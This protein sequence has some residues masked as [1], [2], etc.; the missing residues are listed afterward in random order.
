MRNSHSASKLDLFDRCPLAFRKRYIEKIKIPS[1]N[2]ALTFGSL[3]H[4][5]LESCYRYIVEEEIKGELSDSIVEECCKKAAL[6]I[7]IS[8]V[9]M[10]LMSDA[11][12]LTKSYFRDRNIDCHSILGIEKRFDLTLNGVKVLGYI[13][14]VQRVE[15]DSILVVDFKTNKRPYEQDDI[16]NSMQAGIYWCAA[17]KL[18]PWAKD[19]KF[20]FEMIKSGS[21]QS[22]TN[23]KEVAQ[24]CFKYL[25]VISNK[26]E[27]A[28]KKD[29][30]EAKLHPFCAWCDYRSVCEPYTR[31]MENDVDA[32]EIEKAISSGN[33]STLAK[34][35]D[36]LS[37]KHNAVKQKLNS[38]DK[39]LKVKIKEHNGPLVANGSRYDIITLPPRNFSAASVVKQLKKMKQPIPDYKVLV[40]EFCDFSEYSL[41]K[42]FEFY[43]IDRSVRSMIMVLVKSSARK[44][45]KPVTFISTSSTKES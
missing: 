18:W 38:I 12:A 13:D 28:I 34:L 15:D 29:N 36:E 42:M 1:T 44:R 39:V 22:P 24:K 40:E 27:N 25:P 26:I 3:V 2:T 41:K 21:I 17:K 37:A 7:D 8:G 20:A 23:S 5:C 16:D 30:F 14:F 10:F 43:K 32:V 19:I 45:N 4:A 33:L 9:D 11:V 31:M 6:N 35:H